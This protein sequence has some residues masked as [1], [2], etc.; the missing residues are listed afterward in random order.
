MFGRYTKFRA[1]LENLYGRKDEWALYNREA[2]PVRGNNTN[3]IAEAAM[4]IVKDKILHRTKAYN[5]PQLF[6][7]LTTRLNAY[8][9]ERIVDAALGRWERFQ[10]SRFLVK[11]SDVRPEHISQVSRIMQ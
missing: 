3:N 10:K 4:R 5:V 8:Y 6:D 9:E 7:F 11:C 1:Y 2:M